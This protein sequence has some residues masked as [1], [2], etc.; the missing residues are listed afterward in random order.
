MQWPIGHALKPAEAKGF[1]GIITLATMIGVAID[2]SPL[3]PFK[4]LYWAAILNGIV[5]V[6]IMVVMMKMAVRPDIMGTFVIRPR[7]RRLGWFATGLMA[8]AV[9]AMLVSLFV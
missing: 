9:V 7:L 8:I 2:F 6:P 1:Y 3:D 5:A 4:A